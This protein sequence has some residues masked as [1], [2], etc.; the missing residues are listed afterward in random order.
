MLAVVYKSGL[1]SLYSLPKLFEKIYWKIDYKI[2]D[3]GWWN[4]NVCFY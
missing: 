4:D 3:I 1:L 2:N